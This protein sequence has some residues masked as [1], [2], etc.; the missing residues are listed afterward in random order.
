MVCSLI[1]KGGSTF[2]G[3]IA[4]CILLLWF[5]QADAAAIHDIRFGDHAAFTRIV[6]ESDENLD[7]APVLF[8]HDNRLTMLLTG[9]RPDLVRKVPVDRV[10][11]IETWHIITEKGALRVEFLFNQYIAKLESSV[12]DNPWR[13]IVDV[14]WPIAPPPLTISHPTI[15]AMQTLPNFSDSAF[16]IEPVQLQ[17][18]GAA[19]MIA[20]DT[21]EDTPPLP[22]DNPPAP[23]I[24]ASVASLASSAPD[25]VRD[26][27]LHSEP[28][29]TAPYARTTPKSSSPL[30]YMAVALVVITVGSLTLLLIMMLL[31]RGPIS[32]RQERVQNLSTKE[33]LIAQEK[34][35]AALNGRIKEQLQRYEEA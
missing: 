14:Y 20:T 2:T 15:P 19:T 32:L 25:A 5:S 17:S 4:F 33:C 23:Q 18:D 11:E 34:R 21:T 13:L 28:S 31:P 3:L 30:Y 27:R 29:P 8:E 22:P 10:K 6:L 12:I 9:C 1:K 35:L 26:M 16:Y 7:P 24:S